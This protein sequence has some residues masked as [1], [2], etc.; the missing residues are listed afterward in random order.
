MISVE[1]WQILKQNEMAIKIINIYED[2]LI[3]K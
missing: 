3:K 2:E 1:E